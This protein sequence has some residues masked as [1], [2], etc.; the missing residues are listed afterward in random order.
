MSEKTINDVYEAV[1]L[2]NGDIRVLVEKYENFEKW[3]EQ[4]EKNDKVE[5]ALLHKRVSDTKIYGTAASV[6]TGLIGIF[7]GIKI[8]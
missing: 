8:K 1:L 5:H 4:H 6:L 2:Q 3:R 7:T